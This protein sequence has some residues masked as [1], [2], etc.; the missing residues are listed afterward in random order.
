[1]KVIKKSF[2]LLVVLL[3]LPFIVKASVVYREVRSIDE[4]DGNQKVVFGVDG[5]IFEF[6]DIL[7]NPI[8]KK[9][10]IQDGYIKSDI[11]INNIFIIN[12]EYST[13]SENSIKVKPLVI[14]D[15]T[16]TCIKNTS[17]KKG[18]LYLK[19]SMFHYQDKE[20]RIQEYEYGFNIRSDST[21]YLNYTDG[22]WVIGENPQEIKIYREVDEYKYV[23]D[24]LIIGQTSEDSNLNNKSYVNIHL[25]YDKQPVKNIKFDFMYKN[26]NTVDLKIK[27]IDRYNDDF[28]SSNY[29]YLMSGEYLSSDYLFTRVY[30]KQDSS[31]SMLTNNGVNLSGGLLDNVLGESDVYIYVSSK[32]STEYYIDKQK[33]DISSNGK[34]YISPDS[35]TVPNGYDDAVDSKILE[36]VSY[37]DPKGIES[38]V[39]NIDLTDY[40]SSFTL[41]SN[42]YNLPWYINGKVVSGEFDIANNVAKA[43]NKVFI[44]IAYKDLV[45]PNTNSGKL[46]MLLTIVFCI[47]LIVLCKYKRS[48]KQI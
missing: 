34:Y 12:D 22:A 27:F 6:V 44:F 33:L 26:N 42:K 35:Y 11:G 10:D 41:P 17:C 31:Y 3:C 28:Y 37:V 20:I 39:Y 43:D 36:S 4:L 25:Y 1:M 19:D 18:N 16:V 48:F 46:V 13:L 38:F 8:S 21:H 9:V 15:T 29:E 7:E 23:D 32:Y 30:A 14:G 45:N 5:N 40:E 24:V 47:T 2:S